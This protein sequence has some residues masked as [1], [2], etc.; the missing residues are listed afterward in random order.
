M[1]LGK[2]A[3]AGIDEHLH[4]HMVPRWSGDCNFMSVIGGQRVIPEAFETSF[5]SL[6]DAFAKLLDGKE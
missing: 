4:L 5:S 2:A 6:R 1:N 3:G